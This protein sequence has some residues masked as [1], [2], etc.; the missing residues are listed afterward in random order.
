MR[1]IPRSCSSP[2][3]DSIPVHL[4]TKEAFDVYF[5]RLADDGTIAAHVSNRTLNLASIVARIAVEFDIQPILIESLNDP[6]RGAVQS[7]WVVLCRD[8][9]L[10]ESLA[11]YAK[12]PT[13]S[14]DPTIPL[15]TDNHYG[16][17]PLV[18]MR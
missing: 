8:P 13:V 9:R 14:H 7:K 6:R 1:S 17:W 5:Q 11:K 16:P 12:R 3:R 10:R 4:L 18:R 2:D 15:W